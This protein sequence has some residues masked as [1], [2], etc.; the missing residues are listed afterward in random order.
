MATEL[1]PGEHASTTPVTVVVCTRDRP[2][3]LEPAVRAVLANTYSEFELVVV[4]QSEAEQSAQLLQALANDDRRLRIV[5]DR[6]GRGASRARNLG[7][8]EARTDILVFTDDDCVPSPDWV[9]TMFRVMAE[10]PIA[11]IAYGTVIPAECDPAEGFIVGYAPPRRQ[12]LTR[13][14]D[15]LRDAG[16]GANMALRRSALFAIGGFDEMLGPGSYFPSCEEGDL[17]YR[18]LRGGYALLHVPEA[19]VTHYGLRDW[20]SGRSLARRTYLSVAAAYM[21]HARSRDPVGVCLVAQQIW[22]ACSAVMGAVVRRRRPLGVGRLGAL[23]VGIWRSF[24]LEIDPERGLYRPR[25]AKPA[26]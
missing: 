16:I 6:G 12:R 19:R 17:A 2:D 1:A 22:L 9:A 10:D 4:D 14:V 7:A 20:Q 5:R 24:E 26:A 15:K 3:Q 21:K 23:L 18:M 11:G 8:R 13:P 25:L